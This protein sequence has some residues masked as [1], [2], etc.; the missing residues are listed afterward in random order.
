MLGR[1]RVSFIHGVDTLWLAAVLMLGTVVA[2]GERLG[3]PGPSNLPLEGFV[4]MGSVL[5]IVVHALSQLK[6]QMVHVVPPSASLPS[7]SGT[8]PVPAATNQRPVSYTRLI[9]QYPRANIP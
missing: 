9:S 7:L 1:S 2:D 5:I 4:F 3:C 6:H 8:I